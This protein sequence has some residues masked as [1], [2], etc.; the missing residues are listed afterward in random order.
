MPGIDRLP[1]LKWLIYCQLLCKFRPESYRDHICIPL[2]MVI[3]STV[4]M[5][6]DVD[7]MLVVVLRVLLM[8][9]Y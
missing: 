9:S 4:N 8:L 1:L 7:C 3:I 2:I 6:I 5:I